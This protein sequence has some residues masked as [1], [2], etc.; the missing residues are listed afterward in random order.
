M[1]KVE[2]KDVGTVESLQL[3]SESLR[4]LFGQVEEQLLKHVK[5]LSFISATLN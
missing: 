2:L 5:P 3:F 1:Q 4:A